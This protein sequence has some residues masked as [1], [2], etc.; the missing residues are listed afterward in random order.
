LDSPKDISIK[1]Y[2]YDLPQDRIARFPLEERDAS[3][4]LTYK[5]GQINHH[6]FKT[7]PEHLPASALLVF[8]DTKVIHARLHFYLENGTQIEILCLEPLSP[9]EYQQNLSSVHTVRWKCLVGGNRKWKQGV[10]SRTFD[11]D[12]KAVKLT[13]RREERLSDSF[14]IQFEWDTDELAFG[15]L[16]AQAGIIP[17]PPYLN[18]EAEP[19]DKDRYQTIYANEKGSVAAPT[20]GL[21]F[22]DRV[23]QQLEAHD[24]EPLYLTLHVGAGTFKPV[25]ADRLEGHHMHEESIYIKREQLKRIHEA[26]V[27]QRPVIAVGTTSMRMLESLYWY[28][29][30]LLRQ[31][32]YMPFEV[33][34]WVPYENDVATTAAAAIEQVMIWLD[35]QGLDT[36]VGQTQLIIAPGY[37][38]RIA[39]GLVTNFH[40]PG[41]TLLLLIAALIGEDWRKVYT[42]AMDNDFRFLSYGDSSLL[43]P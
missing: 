41:S 1:D 17:L 40:Q 2:V 36:L 34:Q 30:Q 39:N 35:K 16:L 20:A 33:S 27:Q 42:Y 4:L 7:I 12:G 5:K 24:I 43:L 8:N 25:K 21:H 37:Q 26:L 13:A 11:V 9:L 3:S 14:A 10:I 19:S 29:D 18:R 28:G 31:G 23:F 32:Q 38:F 6:I 15:E 22:T